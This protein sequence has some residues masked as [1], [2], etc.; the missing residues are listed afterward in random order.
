M[1]A[2]GDETGS[3][4]PGPNAG[5]YVDAYERY[6][7]PILAGSRFKRLHIARGDSCYLRSR[8]GRLPFPRVST[9]AHRADGHVGTFDRGFC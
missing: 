9:S 5:A 4:K 1:R 2:N 3:T 6:R 7:D 8:C